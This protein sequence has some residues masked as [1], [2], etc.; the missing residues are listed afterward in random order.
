VRC[1]VLALWPLPWAR[2]TLKHEGWLSGVVS[3]VRAALA[4]V[5]RQRA[6]MGAHKPRE[7]CCAAVSHV[8][9]S[10]CTHVVHVA[11]IMRGD[12]RCRCPWCMWHLRQRVRGVWGDILPACLLSK[13]RTPHGVFFNA[14]PPPPPPHVLTKALCPLCLFHVC[15][16]TGLAP[17]T[18]APGRDPASDAPAGIGAGAGAGSGAAPSAG[19]PMASHGVLDDMV[20]M[21]GLNSPQKKSK[22]FGAV[23]HP[24]HLRIL[25]YPPVRPVD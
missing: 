20:S 10:V 8:C 24:G 17:S 15:V 2:D 16:A 19:V 14:P 23:A 22:R 6:N 5:P 4:A 18:P 3:S 21:A 13:S 11:A 12:H 1:S 25:H 9:L 7:S